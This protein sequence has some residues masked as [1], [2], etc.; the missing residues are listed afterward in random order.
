MKHQTVAWTALPKKSANI[1]TRAFAQSKYNTFILDR[2][3]PTRLH[4]WAACHR[5]SAKENIHAPTPIHVCRY[6]AL[7]HHSLTLYNEV[8]LKKSSLD[9]TGVLEGAAVGDTGVA[10]HRLR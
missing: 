6:A 7:A 9:V 1:D 3:I 8:Y 4:P 2:M 10:A 5:S